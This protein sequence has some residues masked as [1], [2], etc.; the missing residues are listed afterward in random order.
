MA[1]HAHETRT[2]TKLKRGTYNNMAVSCR[3]VLNRLPQ[4]PS[5]STS[6][7]IH[8]EKSCSAGI[9]IRTFNCP[10]PEAILMAT[11]V[12]RHEVRSIETVRTIPRT[13]T[14][15]LSSWPSASSLNE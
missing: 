6:E 11:V 12:S 14:H 4:T 3:C 8:E 13:R 1:S 10:P 15:W 9:G 2:C 7:S 5:T